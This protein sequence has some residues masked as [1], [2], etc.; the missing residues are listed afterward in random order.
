MRRACITKILIL[1]SLSIASAQNKNTI[2][3]SALGVHFFINDFNNRDSQNT[4]KPGLAISFMTGISP[5]IDFVTMLAGSFPETSIQNNHLLLESDASLRYKIFPN[6]YWISPYFQAGIGVSKY[7]DSYKLLLP[8]GIGFQIKLFEEAYLISN[9]QYRLL[10]NSSQTDHL[11]FSIGVAGTINKKRKTIKH[12]AVTENT[13][14]VKIQIKDF[15]GDGIPDSTDACPLVKGFIKYKGC[16]IPDSDGDGINDEEDSCPY[17]AGLAKYKGC[18]ISDRDGDGVND[19]I[20]Q[21]PDMPGTSANY[22]C[23]EISNAL[24]NKI[25]LAAKKIFFETGKYIILSESFSSL[26]I[27]A[28]ILQENKNLKLNVSGH[29]DNVGTAENNQILSENRASAVANYF[30]KKGIDKERLKYAGYGQTK[31]IADNSTITGRAYNRRV[32]MELYYY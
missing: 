7:G 1:L 2:Q 15:D 16:P 6:K 24:I 14:P 22:G 18:P 26:D 12:S 8:T 4:I 32:E 21:C 5:H 11:F 19:E 31:P 9:A 13:A 30:I 3:Q 20:D 28:S 17:V 25:N 27:V 23:P 29:T 10:V